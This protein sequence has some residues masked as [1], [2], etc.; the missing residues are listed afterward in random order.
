MIK[1]FGRESQLS[2]AMGDA[3]EAKVEDGGRMGPWSKG[4]IRIGNSERYTWSEVTEIKGAHERTIYAVD[5]A[6]GGR[7]QAEGG[8]GRMVSCGGDGV[9]NIFQMVSRAR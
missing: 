4:G 1:I 2:T 5:W 6:K 9:I 3:E 7:S 8:L